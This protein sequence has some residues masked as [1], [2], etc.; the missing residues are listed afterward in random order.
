MALC[1]AYAGGSMPFAQ[2]LDR[3]ADVFG[4]KIS[5]AWLPEALFAIPFGFYV[6]DQIGGFAG[7]LG[8]L[9][10]FLWSY[11]WMQTGHGAVLAWG[12]PN[13]EREHTL[14]PVVNWLADYFNIDRGGVGYCRLF[15]AVKGFLIGV[16]TGPGAIVTAILWPAAYEI[17]YRARWHHG[18]TEALTGI[19]AALA[20][21]AVLSGVDVRGLND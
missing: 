19:A 7:E 12:N 5:F 10:A 21:L 9:I 8:G 2:I 17:G 15:M 4:R 11:G 3:E 6:A 14:T 1:A 13:P 16:P 20:I 18:F